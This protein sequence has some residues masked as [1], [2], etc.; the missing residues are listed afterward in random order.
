MCVYCD[1]VEWVVRA[2]READSVELEVVT[3]GVVHII[4]TTI[5]ASCVVSGRVARPSLEELC[6]IG[7]FLGGVKVIAKHVA[8]K[9][10]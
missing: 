10:L 8:Y 4:V 2:E 6:S 5:D 1:S 3:V 7:S 9:N